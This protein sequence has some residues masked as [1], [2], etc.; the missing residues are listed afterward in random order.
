ML[1][2]KRIMVYRKRIV[3]H[4]KR[5]Q[6]KNGILYRS[7]FCKNNSSGAKHVYISKSLVATVRR[8]NT[9]LIKNSQKYALLASATMTPKLGVSY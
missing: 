8:Q 5:I 2:Q 7:E 6:Q 1:N 4:Q 9:F 3:L